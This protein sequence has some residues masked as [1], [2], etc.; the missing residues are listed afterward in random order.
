MPVAPE[1]FTASRSKECTWTRRLKAKMEKEEKKNTYCIVSPA[2]ADG[3]RLCRDRPMIRQ[4]PGTGDSLELS[5]VRDW[6]VQVLE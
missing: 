3:S 2:N 5:A 6:Q 1:Y 4:V